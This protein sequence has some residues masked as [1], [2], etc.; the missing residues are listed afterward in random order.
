MPFVKM[1]QKI[2]DWINIYTI[3]SIDSIDSIQA[4][5]LHWIHFVDWPGEIHNGRAF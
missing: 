5:N 4:R 3:K 1:Q 2:L